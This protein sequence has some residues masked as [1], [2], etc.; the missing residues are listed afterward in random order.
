MGEEIGR[1]V[2]MPLD[3]FINETYA[4]LEAGQEEIIVVGSV[5]PQETF[6]EVV[7]KRLVAFR[8]LTS[9]FLPRILGGQ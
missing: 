3:A 5:G 6:R 2:G 1:S 7:E 8:E 4:R 9:V